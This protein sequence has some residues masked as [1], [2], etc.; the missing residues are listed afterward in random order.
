MAR[1]SEGKQD[2]VEIERI[3]AERWAKEAAADVALSPQLQTDKTSEL[4][5]HPFKEFDSEP[6]FIAFLRDSGFEWEPRVR[7]DHLISAT[8]TL[9][10]MR[11]RFSFCIVARPSA[12]P[13]W[14]QIALGHGCTEADAR[15]QCFKLAGIN[16]QHFPYRNGPEMKDAEWDKDEDGGDYTRERENVD[17]DQD[18]YE[19]V[20]VKVVVALDVEAEKYGEGGKEN[21]AQGEEYKDYEEDERQE[22]SRRNSGTEREEGLMDILADFSEAESTSS[23]IALLAEAA[24]HPPLSSPPVPQA[25][26]AAPRPSN[27]PSTPLR[28][29]SSQSSSINVARESRTEAL[30]KAFRAAA[31]KY[32]LHQIVIAGYPGAGRPL[33]GEL[34]RILVLTASEPLART[35]ARLVAQQRGGLHVLGKSVGFI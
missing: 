6:V 11:R 15:A 10:A 4:A 13:R 8:A 16:Q 31:R 21:E 28:E 33:A 25:Q 9:S 30:I 20:K 5:S 27:H 7:C 12:S 3:S 24:E 18:E 14:R 22:S 1:S 17:Q 34:P 19:V 26:V 2:W 23:D 35:H 29:N 32:G